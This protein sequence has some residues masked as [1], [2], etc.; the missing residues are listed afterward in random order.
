MS[1][2]E[3]T[4]EPAETAGAR[5][6]PAAAAPPSFGGAASPDEAPSG[7]A[8]SAAAGT[9]PTPPAPRSLPPFG[10]QTPWW[11][12][13]TQDAAPAVPHQAP[14]P[15]EAP[16]AAPVEVPAA[17]PVTVPEP[18]GAAE[19][20]PPVRAVVAAVQAPGDSPGRLVAG[21]GVPSVDSR[22]AVP[23][24]PLLGPPPDDTDT[25]PDGIPAV[26]PAQHL[27]KQ[28]EEAPPAAP[29]PEPEPEAAE[30]EAA[31][32]SA[33]EKAKEAEKQ[34]VPLAP[35]LV[36]DAI[37]PP[38]VVPPT[39][40]GPFPSTGS[41]Q[42]PPPRP[43]G[44]AP[45]PMR[46]GGGNMRR[47][48]L[49]GGGAAVV[50]AA[51]IGLFAIG[52]T[53]SGSE[54]DKG[55]AAPPTQQAATP[56]PKPPP[57]DISDEKTDPK[58]MEFTE[59]FPAPTITLGGR[60]YVRD[61]WSINKDLRYAANGAMLSALTK[62]NCRKVVRATFLDRNRDIAVT[63]GVAVLPTKAAALKVSR[64]GDPGKYEWFRGMSAKHAPDIDRAGG[65]AAS[66]VRG[67]YLVYA[68]VQHADGKPTKPG[69]A[70][71]KQIAQQFLDYDVR[72][73]EA[74]NHG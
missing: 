21:R 37:L 13:E 71:I 63:S 72:P 3:D 60:P 6:V 59:I 56:A 47:P 57:V 2:P 41:E 70:M 32:L 54:K 49:I 19:E 68:Y 8:A 65:Y 40:S 35:V 29:E 73:I 64:A 10:L 45:P 18:P 30:K 20:Q 74:R 38:G 52:G 23:A 66:T 43:D 39:G 7:D 33:F 42:P 36:P 44:A 22:R 62:E 9:E 34:Q 67:R 1:G 61:R 12:A 48:L 14:A 69:D 24:E 5:A 58:E 28:P 26:R 4:R 16:L 27:V 50:L 46:P 15:V 17:A 51:V 11:A 31:R 55:K 53:G 25:D